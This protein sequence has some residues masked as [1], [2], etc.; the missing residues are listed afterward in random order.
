MDSIEQHIKADKEILDNPM[1][2]PQKRRH[3]EEELHELEVYA[4]NHKEEIEAGDHHYPSALELYCEVEPGAPE[5]K[6]H[7]N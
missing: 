1:T 5:C 7:D 3:V 4:E 6:I 2:S